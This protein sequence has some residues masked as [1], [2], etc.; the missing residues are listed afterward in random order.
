M[1]EEPGGERVIAGRY[2]LLS[3]L[4]EGGMGTVWRARDEVLN[5]EVAVKE[6]RAP[7]GLPESD[8][9]ADVRPRWSA[10]RG[11]R[12]GSPTPTSSRC[13]TWSTD[14]GRPWIVMELVRGLSLA[15]LLDAEG[16][17]PPQRAALIGAEVLAALRAAHA[18]GVLHRDVKPANVL[19]PTTAGWCSPTSA[20]PGSRAAPR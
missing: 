20:S 3:P 16:P 13:T 2:R 14:G 19:L 8:V 10:R 9:R 6:V 12:P 17:L 1:F 7:A 15:D 11:P 4:G 5:R 18:A